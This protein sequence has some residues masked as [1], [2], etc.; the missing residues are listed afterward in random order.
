MSY[1]GFG[2]YR[3][4]DYYVPVRRRRRRAGDFFDAG[5][6]TDSGFDPS[7]FT[8]PGAGPDT[9]LGT[10]D[11]SDVTGGSSSVSTDPSLLGQPGGIP[12]DTMGLGS[13]SGAIQKFIGGGSSLIPSFGPGVG[14]AAGT[15]AAAASSSI[16]KAIRKRLARAITGKS[17]HRHMNPGNFKALRRSLRRLKS[18]EHA[19]K[20]VYSF[21]HR[22][23]G[24]A[25]FKFPKRRRR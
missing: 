20:R 17:G 1:R 25:K 9:S 6:L 11:F 5:T 4:G 14:A 23:P 18:F 22:A 8:D 2:G 13:I 7:A 12:I 15:A 19:A 10:P 3:A 24:R 16:G 21:T